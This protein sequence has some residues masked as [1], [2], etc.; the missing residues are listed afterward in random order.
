[1][2][3]SERHKQ[4]GLRSGALHRAPPIKHGN[5]GNQ[6]KDPASARPQRES[7][8]LPH[9]KP[10]KPCGNYAYH[11]GNF[12]FWWNFW[13]LGM[14]NLACWAGTGPRDRGVVASSSVIWKQV[15]SRAD[16]YAVVKHCESHRNI[17]HT[18]VSPWA[19]RRHQ[20]HKP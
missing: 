4:F 3:S 15:L 8:G 2:C 11:R 1:M 14:G 9:G 6:T 17:D 19:S 7:G 16:A 20:P 12:G 10:H 13:E 18:S 5:A